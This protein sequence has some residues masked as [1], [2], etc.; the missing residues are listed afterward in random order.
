MEYERG[1]AGGIA[2]RLPIDLVAVT[3]I[4][5]AVIVGFYVWVPHS[6]TP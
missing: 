5:H 3:G 2:A 4:E 6:R 1:L